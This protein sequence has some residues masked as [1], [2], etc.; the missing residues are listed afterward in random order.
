MSHQWPAVRLG[1][2]QPPIPV[3]PAISLDLGDVPGAV[4]A[5]IKVIEPSGAVLYF[6]CSASPCQVQVDARQG[7]PWFQILYLDSLG[8][9]PAAV[10]AGDL[11]QLN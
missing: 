10:E 5:L 4:S 8:H 3:T 6:T 11:M 9:T 2:V 1:G 7:A